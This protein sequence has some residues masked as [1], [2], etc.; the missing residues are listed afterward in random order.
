M[1]IALSCFTALLLIMKKIEN[2]LWIVLALIVVMAVIAASA[3][4]FLRNGS[5]NY[6]GPYGMMG[7]GYA[8]MIIFYAGNWGSISGFRP[9]IHILLL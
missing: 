2:L 3:A 4:I 6:Y 9:Y 7:G 5:G 8:G 1:P